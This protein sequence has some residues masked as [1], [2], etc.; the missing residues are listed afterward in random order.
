MKDINS[1]AHTCIDELRSVGICPPPIEEFTVN[2]RAKTRWGQCRK[3][4]GKFYINISSRLLDESIS[5]FPVKNTLMHEILHTMPNCFNHGDEW[6]ELA[7][8]VNNSLATDKVCSY[9]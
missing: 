9:R 6:S 3:R 7:E 2:T 5:D 1:I 8:K 4:W